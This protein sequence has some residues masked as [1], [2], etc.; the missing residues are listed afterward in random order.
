MVE[1]SVWS[2]SQLIQVRFQVVVDTN[3]CHHGH[4]NRGLQLATCD[5]E[6]MHEIIEYYMTINCGLIRE[7]S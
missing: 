5:R 2:R 7:V 1:E 3:F 6:T 4:I